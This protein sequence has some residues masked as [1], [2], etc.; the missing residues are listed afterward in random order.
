MVV[1]LE[2][3][4]HKYR[5]GPVEV[6]V[7][8][9]IDFSLEKGE[10]V[11][12]MGVSGA[13]KSTLLHILG[14]LL[15]PDGGS[16]LLGGEEML[17]AGE[18]RLAEV[19]S[20]KIGQVF[21]M[22]H[23]LAEM[24]VRQNVALPFLY[25][26][27][28]AK[29]AAKRVDEAI[30]KVGLS[31]RIHHRPAELSGGEMQRTAIARVL[32]QRPELILADEPTGNLDGQNSRDILELFAEMHREGQSIVMVTHDSDVAGYAGKILRLQEGRLYEL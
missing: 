8:D 17:G 7:L 15:Q 30:E 22:F 31:S 19:R 10:F 13:G 20:E 2:K 24:N 32:A 27:V 16:Y 4:R 28:A 18:R 12:I 3:L 29:E 9:G 5:H 1:R 6:L 11:A 23:L 26:N 21:Q 14:C 25:R